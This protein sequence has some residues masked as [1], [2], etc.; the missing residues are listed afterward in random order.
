MITRDGRIYL[1]DLMEMGADGVQDVMALLV[2]ASDFGSAYER[3]GFTYVDLRNAC[4]DKLT[5]DA[6]TG[7]WNECVQCGHFARDKRI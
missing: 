4:R 1:N 2:A 3:D 6:F 5:R 7:A